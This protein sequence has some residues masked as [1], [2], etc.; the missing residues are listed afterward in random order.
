ML[1]CSNNGRTKY[2]YVNFTDWQVA[3]LEFSCSLTVVSPRPASFP[4]SP[5]NKY[6]NYSP[7]SVHGSCR[8][9]DRRQQPLLR[10]WLYSSL[11]YHQW[12]RSD[13]L[14]ALVTQNRWAALK[15]A[16]TTRIWILSIPGAIE[17]QTGLYQ[18]NHT[19]L[20]AVNKVAEGVIGI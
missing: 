7:C 9:P 13:G 4:G 1:G 5:S 18:D 2:S 3:M 12:S 15:A 14:W 20:N 19:C 17:S 6:M 8:S 16:S 10:D 11:G